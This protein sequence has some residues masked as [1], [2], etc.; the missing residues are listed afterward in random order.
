MGESGSFEQLLEDCLDELARTGE[1]ESSLQRYPQVADRLRPLLE[2]AQATRHYYQV[3]PAAPGKLATGRERLLAAAAQQ[4]ARQAA[5]VMEGTTTKIASKPR[6]RLG[7][8]LRLMTLVLAVVLVMVSLGGGLAWAAGN[9]LPGDLIYSV[10]VATEDMR[11]ALASEPRDEVELALGFVEER[12]EEMQELVEAGRQV[13]DGTFARME[14]HIERALNEAAGADDEEIGGLLKQIAA[15]TRAQAQELEGL[16][17]QTEL[18]RAA[19]ICGRGAD[20]ADEGL[21]D[22]STFRWRYR[23]REG[24]PRPTSDPEQRQEPHREQNQKQDGTG[25]RAPAATPSVTL[26]GPRASHTP[27]ATPESLEPTATPQ[28]TP[29][30]QQ[31]TAGPKETSAAPQATA[32]PSPL[33]TAG[34]RGTPQHTAMPQATPHHLRATVE[35]QPTSQDPPAKATSHAA[36]QDPSPT[37]GNPRETPRPKPSDGGQV[38]GH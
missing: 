25:E 1:I 2:L 9:S 26:A 11:L 22:P 8:S 28:A 12:A 15:R 35:A 16:R 31:G 10:K 4:R 32:M 7:L 18:V 3:V 29:R 27:H 14:G 19:A 23:H 33:P 13:P 17:A 34:P 24:E 37:P 30:G 21:S 6:L 38:G 36:P 5:A 20:A